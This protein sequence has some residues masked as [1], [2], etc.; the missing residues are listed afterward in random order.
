MQ[1]TIRI[2]LWSF[3]IENILDKMG[4]A[5][6]VR[7]ICKKDMVCPV[8]L[9][10]KED[11]SQWLKMLRMLH[12]WYLIHD[13]V[14]KWKNFPRYWPFVQGPVTRSFDVFFDLPQ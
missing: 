3:S 4:H 8:L 6:I 9:M 1:T 11:L 2:Y 12:C 5:G 13:D 14:I 10:V 7:F